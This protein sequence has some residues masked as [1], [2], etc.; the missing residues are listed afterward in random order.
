VTGTGYAV[1]AGGSQGGGGGPGGGGSSSSGIG[2][3]V[4]GYYLSTSSLSYSANRYYSIIS[5][6]ASS[7]ASAMFTYS[8]EGS[9]SSKLSLFTAKGMTSGTTY[10]VK[11]STSA[12][13]GATNSFHG[14]YIGGT[15]SGTLTQLTSFT[16]TK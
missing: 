4:Q 15:T 1:S 2:S 9:C 8:F 12:P 6:N 11:Y 3:S 13:T 5:T 7:N 10:Y 14:V 16:A